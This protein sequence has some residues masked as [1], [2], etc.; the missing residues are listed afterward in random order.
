MRPFHTGSGPL[1]RLLAVVTGM[2]LLVAAFMFSVVILAVIAL[3][4]L[5]AW[6][7][8]WWKT[9]KL[10]KAMREHPSGGV[11]I[12][13]EAIVV[14]DAQSAQDVYLADTQ[15]ERPGSPYPKS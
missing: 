13:G 1:G 8:F 15:D 6:G 7:Y 5:A 14:D 2:I 3:A 10:R 9:R 12:D 4:G 11:V